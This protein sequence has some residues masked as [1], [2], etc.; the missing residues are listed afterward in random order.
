MKYFL[1]RQTDTYPR[2]CAVDQSSRICCADSRPAIV[3]LLYICLINRSNLQP[4]VRLSL[5][6]HSLADGNVWRWWVFRSWWNIRK[7]FFQ[8]I[9]SLSYSWCRR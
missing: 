7:C 9:V 4:K 8:S 5:S 2:S 1:D 3:P 6:K